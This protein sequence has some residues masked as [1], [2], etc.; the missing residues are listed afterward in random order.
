M[1]LPGLTW[2][3]ALTPFD[4]MFFIFH[5]LQ[6]NCGNTLIILLKHLQQSAREDFWIDMSAVSVM[7]LMQAFVFASRLYLT[8]N[9][10]KKYTASSEV[11]HKDVWPSKLVYSSF[12]RRRVLGNYFTLIFIHTE[13]AKS[14]QS[15]KWR[16]GKKMQESSIRSHPPALKQESCGRW[17]SY[18]FLKSCQ[19]QGF[20]SFHR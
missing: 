16:T 9:I 13:S 3:W 5:G 2:S 19:L 7:W 18:C 1:F 14:G 20:Q 8:D 15:P 4:F 10:P 17:L 6:Y 12:S 11:G